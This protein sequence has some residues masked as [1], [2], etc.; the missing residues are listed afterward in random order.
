M[1]NDANTTKGMPCPPDLEIELK[2]SKSVENFFAVMKKYPTHW[3]FLN[4]EVFKKLD[5]NT[6]ELVQLID[7]YTDTVSK[8]KLDDINFPV[9]TFD[10]KFY[11]PINVTVDVD[12]SHIT[13]GDIF[14]CQ[15]QLAKFLSIDRSA[16][17]L[18]KVL[19]GSLRLVFVF[20]AGVLLFGLYNLKSASLYYHRHNEEVTFRVQLGSSQLQGVKD[21]S[22]AGK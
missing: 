7:N 17:I 12:P 14:E 8:M 2:R 10:K 3:N 15:S 1:L 13:I 22:G 6:Q 11:T 18:V 19:A 20:G 21:N 16:L 5:G 9:I 4:I